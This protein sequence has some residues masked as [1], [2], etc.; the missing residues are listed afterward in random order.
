MTTEAMT[1]EEWTAFREESNRLRA[2]ILALPPELRGRCDCCGRPNREC[3]F[4]GN[5]E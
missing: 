2:A 5:V 4:G 1:T 3:P